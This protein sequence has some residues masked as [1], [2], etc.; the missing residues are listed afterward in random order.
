MSET[1][2][3]KLFKHDNPS[4]NTNSFD[5]E[6]ALNENWNKIDTAVGDLQ[7]DVEENNTNID[8]RLT[9]LETDL[10]TAKTDITNIKAEQTTQNN[11]I[12]ANS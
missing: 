11:N 5:V 2:N 12:E 4:T 9:E 7:D 6:Q 8:T 3:L 10:G 1:T